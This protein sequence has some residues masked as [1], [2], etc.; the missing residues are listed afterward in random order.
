MTI[1]FSRRKRAF[2]WLGV[3]FVLVI[4]GLYVVFPVVMGIVAVFPIKDSVGVAPDGFNEIALETS[5]GVTLAGWYTPT[6]NGAA[7]VL[8]HGAGNSREGVRRYADLLAGHGYGVLAIDLRGHGESEGAV[9]KLGWQG[10]RDIEAAAAYLQ[11]QPGVERI[12]ALGLSMGGEVLL[13]AASTVP[14]MQAIVADG[15][16]RRCTEEL[17]ALPSE[18]SLVRSYTARVMY[19]TVQVL[20]GDD[21]PEPPLLNSMQQA[22]NTRFYLIAGGSNALEVDFNELFA[23]TLGARAELWVAPDAT[24]TGALN[25]YPD[26][27]EQRVIGFFNET[28]IGVSAE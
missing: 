23:E 6:R 26:E 13:G 28:L 12:G 8:V 16:T 20:T 24:H 19:A 7:I 21:P 17:R 18:R 25:R 27:Y 11:S 15:A 3:L 1:T 2:R 5:D 14:A 4:I 22:E 9:N 10:T